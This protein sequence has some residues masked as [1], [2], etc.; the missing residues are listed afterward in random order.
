MELTTNKSEN[1]LTIADSKKALTVSVL[2]SFVRLNKKQ[3][4][5]EVSIIVEDVLNQFKEVHILDIIE[6]IKLGST[7]E[8]GRTFNLCVQE[9]CIWVK[10]YVK[11][12]NSID[13]DLY[14]Y[15]RRR[16]DFYL[17]I[18][19]MPKGFFLSEGDSYVDVSE[20]GQL[21]KQW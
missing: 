18:R 13:N 9:F 4:S 21:K 5:E 12:D 11:K 7:G 3:K 1:Y 2:K 17:K 14:D 20:I 19:R 6:A 10:E 8:Y 16:K 15:Y